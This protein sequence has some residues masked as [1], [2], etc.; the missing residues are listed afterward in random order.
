M[1][2][3]LKGFAATAAASVIL[4]KESEAI[5]LVLPVSLNSAKAG[6]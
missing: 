4:A 2:E 5:K 3:V 1:I 6:P